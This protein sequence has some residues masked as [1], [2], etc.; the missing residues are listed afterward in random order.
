MLPSIGIQKELV[1]RG[2]SRL[3][4]Q[5]DIPFGVTIDVAATA[6][7]IAAKGIEQTLVGDF[8]DIPLIVSPDMSAADAVNS[9]NE[10]CGYGQ[11]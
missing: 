9:Y 5:I 3:L 11:A 10:A 1:E 8:N 4:G 7:E 2:H 6:L